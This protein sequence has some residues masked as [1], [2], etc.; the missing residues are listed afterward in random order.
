MRTLDW[1]LNNEHDAALGAEHVSK[2]GR[3][4]F[5]NSPIKICNLDGYYLYMKRSEEGNPVLTFS[6]S[7]LSHEHKKK[8][9][10]CRNS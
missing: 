9:I 6:D 8:V 5:V 10:L 3:Q 4:F 2:W 7:Q 1:C